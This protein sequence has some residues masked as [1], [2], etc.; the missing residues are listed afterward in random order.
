MD[1][2]CHFGTGA[3]SEKKTD[4]AQ[5]AM[6]AQRAR[7]ATG[8]GRVSLRGRCG[9]SLAAAFGIAACLDRPIGS[10]PPV[11]TN[12]FLDRIAQTSVDKIDLLFMIDNSAS[13]SDKQTILQLAVPDLVQRLVNPACIDAAGRRGATP[14][15]TLPCP[16]GQTREFDAI[17]DIHVAV[18]SS[19]LGDA[20][21]NEA[22][23]P[24]GSSGYVPDAVDLAHPIGLLQRGRGIGG[25]E[26][27]FLEWRAGVTDESTFA[28]QFQRMVSSVGENGCGWEAS[29]EAWY[30]FLI[31][32]FPYR[33][34]VRAR[35]PGS[36]SNQLG[37]V[38]A[39]SDADGK[40]LL[41]EPLLAARRAFL[42][43]DSLLAIIM[44]SD[45]N[46][47]SIAV[48]GSSWAVGTTAR[49]MNRA[50]SVCE[51]D[52]NAACCYPCDTRVPEGCQPDP[53]C[54]IA[55][56]PD[57]RGR[58]AASDDAPNLRC[59]DQKRRFGYD[60]LYPIA[61]YVNALREPELCYGR[62]DLSLEGCAEGDRVANPLL[63]RRDPSLV[64]LGGIIGVPWQA[65]AADRDASGAPLGPNTLRFKNAAELERDDVW[66][67]IVG[68]GSL[69]PQNPLMI[70][71]AFPRRGVTPGNPVNGREYA[72]DGDVPGTPQDLEYAC[73]FPLPE[74]RDCSTRTPGVDECDCYKDRHDR[75]LCEAEPGVSRSGTLQYWAKA[76]PG[77]RQL[78]VLRDYGDNSIVASICARNVDVTTA[79]ERADF[80]YRPAIDAIVDRLKEQLGDRCLPRGLL[81]GADGSVPCTL[82]EVTPRPNER[83]ECDPTIARRAPESRTAAAI[84]EQLASDRAAPCGDDDP[85]CARACL[86]EVL[87]VQQAANPDPE[88]ALAACRQDPNAS[89]AEGWCYI[90]DTELQTIGN[91]DLVAGCPPT[92]RQLLRFVVEGLRRN[93]TTFVACQGSSLAA[94][95]A[96]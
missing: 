78:E 74:Q 66:A 71:S 38:Q 30:R 35:C 31:D 7:D 93:T 37:C 80:G 22:C 52:P 64:F 19:S 15:A 75:P 67:E 61:R 17:E 82:V 62:A 44:L 89:G 48:G 70:E 85:S 73:I 91:P 81:T 88:A 96:E 39:E 72:T 84:R 23:P 6:G 40:M 24:P 45:E 13:M 94:Q 10:L 54:D 3:R 32:P 34:L 59:F 1:E 57:T 11:T 2:R 36:S 47:C 79:A 50:S 29:L 65:I 51:S 53:A 28:S 4:A 87:Q 20:G 83:C 43:P 27:G 16:T 33:G 56:T 9:L 76:Y 8:S 41:D 90:A 49:R 21:A 69:P 12:V 55:P 46:D 63:Q 25:N 5:A 60:F 58:L 26:H 68:S 95:R 86:C 92:K 42:R 14:A 18:I 77:L